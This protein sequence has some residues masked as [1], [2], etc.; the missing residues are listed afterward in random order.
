[1][2]DERELREMLGRRASTISAAPTDAPKAI[3][4]ARRRIALN[5]AVGTLVGLVVL[6]GALAGMRIIQAAPTPAEPPTPRPTPARLGSL[7]YAVDGDIYVAEWDG[8]NPVRIANGRPATD[9]HGIGEYWWEGPIWSP[10]GRYLAYRHTDCDGARG[11][12]SDVVISDPEGD[13]VAS[14]PSEGWGISWSP[15]STRVAVWV[16][17][18]R[19]E[20][21]VFGP[22]GERQ[23]LTVPPG[24]MAPPGPRAPSGPRWSPDGASLRVKGGVVVPLDG[25][26]PWKLPSG[27]LR[28]LASLPQATYSPDGSRV[29]YTTSGSLVVAAA[30]GSDPRHLVERWVRS[31]VWS[32]TGDRIA[33]TWGARAAAWRGNATEL[34]VLDVATGRMTVL[35]EAGGS[36]MLSGAASAPFEFSPEGDRILFSGTEV[37]DGT[38]AYSLWS[39]NVDGSNLR[40]LVA[41]TD[42]GDWLSPSPTR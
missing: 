8:S 26:T 36:V 15:D 5:A 2:I 9:C 21:G 16:H 12:W 11:A 17:W 23:T 4:R 37:E 35:V 39:V 41:E 30:D 29:A 1:M 38:F 32:P 40:R 18:E 28:S 22:D 25:S 7:A 20:I 10:D 14:F 13:V 33:F 3:R 19:G 24:M 6:A 31:P 34:R 27:D 42:S